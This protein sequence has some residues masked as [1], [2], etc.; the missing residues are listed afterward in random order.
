MVPQLFL[1]A[2][3]G[4]SM[5]ECGLASDA[6]YAVLFTAV[7]FIAALVMV[8][9]L[10]RADKILDR[11]FTDGYFASKRPASEPSKPKPA[12][13]PRPAIQVVELG[14][15]KRDPSFTYKP[16]ERRSKRP[17]LNRKARQVSKD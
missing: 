1:T 17:F 13:R 16:R 8:V 10:S 4:L 9:V 14:A 6:M 11:I 15:P 3:A 7:G 5:N 2:T 12:S